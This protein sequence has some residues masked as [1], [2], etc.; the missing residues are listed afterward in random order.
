MNNLIPYFT[1]DASCVML[2]NISLRNNYSVYAIGG[3]YDGHCP[4]G[5]CLPLLAHSYF[6]VMYVYC[7]VCSW[8]NK[9]AY[10]YW[11][12]LLWHENA[13]TVNALVILDVGLIS[14]FLYSVKFE[15][16]RI[17]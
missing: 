11:T 16:K 7:I 8:R 2:I 4:T 12:P 9:Y 5:N 10:Y 14:Y 3:R 1:H 15:V 17:S 13:A 6:I